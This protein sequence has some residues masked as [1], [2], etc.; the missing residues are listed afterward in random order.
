MKATTP[1][2]QIVTTIIICTFLVAMFNLF[3]ALA[4]YVG[5]NGL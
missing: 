1:L 3:M 2:D 4:D 5:R